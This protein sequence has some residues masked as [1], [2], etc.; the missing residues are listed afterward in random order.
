M[1]W[2]QAEHIQPSEDVTFQNSLLLPLL[3]TCLLKHANGNMRTTRQRQPDT[4]AA[5]SDLLKLLKTED[6]RGKKYTT[7]YGKFSNKNQQLGAEVHFS[8]Q[9]TCVGSRNN[10][11]QHCYFCVAHHGKPSQRLL[12]SVVYQMFSV[13]KRKK[14][15]MFFSLAYRIWLDPWV[16]KIMMI[17]KQTVELK[18]QK[19]AEKHRKALRQ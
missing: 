16:V 13:R 12:N 7:S 17:Y 9:A 3:I 4:P 8:N 19:S 11:P 5:P 10:P 2:E 1:Q 15:S 14:S 6:S 18:R